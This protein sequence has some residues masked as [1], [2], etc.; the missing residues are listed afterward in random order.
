[1]K[2]KKLLPKEKQSRFGGSSED[3]AAGVPH[4]RATP[5]LVLPP[6]PQKKHPKVLLIL[7]YSLYPILFQ[8]SRALGS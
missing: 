2:T 4:I 1:M 3:Y 5:F 8:Y 7:E 6:P